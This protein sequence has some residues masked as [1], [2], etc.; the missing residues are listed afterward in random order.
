MSP[1]SVCFSGLMEVDFCISVTV[2]NV[3]DLDTGQKRPPSAALKLRLEL[4]VDE[5]D[6]LCTEEKLE[7]GL[8][9]HSVTLSTTLELL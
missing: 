4:G 9:P 7:E 8:L 1:S 3:S 2:F 6:V 5:G